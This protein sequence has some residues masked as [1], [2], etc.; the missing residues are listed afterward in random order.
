V[1]L[2]N[3]V[4]HGFLSDLNADYTAL[5]LRAAALLIT[6]SPVAGDLGRHVDVLPALRPLSGAARVAD[7]ILSKISAAGL[8]LHTAI[9]GR[10]IRL[11]RRLLDDSSGQTP[12]P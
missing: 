9:E 10:R 2:R 12:P 6:A 1:N 8:R 11:R 7:T 4:A 5:V 3:E